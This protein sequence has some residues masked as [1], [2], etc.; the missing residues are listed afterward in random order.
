M[1][2]INKNQQAQNIC[3][4]FAQRRTNV[5]DVGPALYKCCTNV[6]CLLG[7]I[8][9]N[10][11]EHGYSGMSGQRGLELTMMFRQINCI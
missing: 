7:I 11:R 4:T 6:L 3:I 8:Y 9:I 10:L 1:G 5:F 2:Y